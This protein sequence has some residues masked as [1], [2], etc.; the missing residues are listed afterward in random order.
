MADAAQEV[1]RSGFLKLPNKRHSVGN[2]HSKRQIKRA[3]GGNLVILISKMNII[4]FGV[5]NIYILS[6]T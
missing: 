3:T 5:I 1:H 2:H 4:L 6:L